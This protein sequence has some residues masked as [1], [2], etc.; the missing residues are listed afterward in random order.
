MASMTSQSRVVLTAVVMAALSTPTS[1]LY[2]VAVAG[3]AATVREGKNNSP[4]VGVGARSDLQVSALSAPTGAAVGSMI[5]ISDTT[6]NAGGGN[7]NASVTSFYLSSNS[8]LDPSDTRLAPAR[9][10]GVL[11]AGASSA[12]TSNVI[13]PNIAPGVWF[14]IANG[15]DGGLV[16]ETS[17]TNNLRFVSIHIGPD[18]GLTTVTAPATARAESTILVTDGVKNVGLG[19]AGASATRYY[20]STNVTLDAGD[21][22]LDAERVAPALDPNATCT[23]TA[24]VALPAGVAGRYYLI[25]VADGANAVAE[26]NETNN[27]FARLITIN[28]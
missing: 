20:L 26:S 27:A 15:D 13:I 16:T 28:P 19:T 14:L 21:T 3:N 22:L 11:A 7:A 24:S 9:A 25:A 6:R 1:N 5:V 2:L 12:G 4:S 18:L 10:V 8:S 17:E 23:G